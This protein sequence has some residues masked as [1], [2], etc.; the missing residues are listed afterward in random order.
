VEV[1]SDWRS[2]VHSASQPLQLTCL[3]IMSRVERSGR[4]EGRPEWEKIS[5]EERRENT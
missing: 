1:E 2:T 3:M 4:G 5:H